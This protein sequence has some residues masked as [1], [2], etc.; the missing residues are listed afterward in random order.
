M[1]TSGCTGTAPFFRPSGQGNQ[2]AATID[3]LLVMGQ[4]YPFRLGTAGA[5]SGLRIVDGSWIFAPVDVDCSLLSKWD[6]KRV[7][8][9]GN[10]QVTSTG[11]DIPCS[12][13]GG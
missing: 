4:G 7:T 11:G 8:I 1:R 3:G 13:T 10:Y 5:V 9:D 2:G 12:G 6:A